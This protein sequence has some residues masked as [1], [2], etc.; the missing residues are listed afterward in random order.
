M[1]WPFG[2]WTF[3]GHLL[4]HWTLAGDWCFDIKAPSVVIS[5]QYVLADPPF[6]SGDYAPVAL[7]RILVDGYSLLHN[8]PQL[9]KGKSRFSAAARD[10]LIYMLRQYRDASG[11]PITVVFDGQGPAPQT[12]QES[13]STPE[14]EILYSR[15]G[16]T[17][18]DI[19]E[20]VSHLLRPYGDFLVVTDDFAERDTIINLGGFACSCEQFIQMM[21]GTL[22][23][24]KRELSK[25]NQR[26]R[27]KF[28]N[29]PLG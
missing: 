14:M 26:E 5:S 17:A 21:G 24:M 6:A 28:K 8:W 4:R 7:I 19:I 12:D 3:L 23:D 20:R 16:Q 11:T 2:G 15:S 1:A 22:Q 18:D 13:P 29:S 9:A 25:H 27:R 10:E